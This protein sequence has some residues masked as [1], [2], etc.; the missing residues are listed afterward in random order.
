M[1]LHRSGQRPQAPRDRGAPSGYVAMW[2]ARKQKFGAARGG[3]QRGL[4]ASAP[5]LQRTAAARMASAVALWLS[6]R[7]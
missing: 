5:K 1:G 2:A 6:G 3:R 7:S 4:M